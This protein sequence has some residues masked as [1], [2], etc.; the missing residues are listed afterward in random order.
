V[1][2]GDGGREREEGE[3]TTEGVDSGGGSVKGAEEDE[4]TD[5]RRENTIDPAG[6]RADEVSTRRGGEE[7]TGKKTHSEDL[8][9]ELSRVGRDGN[10]RSTKPGG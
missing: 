2:E 10:G 3:V 7:R 1:G 8:R 4:E 6:L 5:D 9:L